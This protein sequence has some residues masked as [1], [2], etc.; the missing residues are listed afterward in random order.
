[1]MDGKISEGMGDGEICQLLAAPGSRWQP[2][3]VPL[4]GWDETQK[5]V[6]RLARQGWPCLCCD[7]SRAARAKRDGRSVTS[8][9]V[10]KT[11]RQI[12]PTT[13]PFLCSYTKSALR[14]RGALVVCLVSAGGKSRT[15]LLVRHVLAR[16]GG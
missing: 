11:S 16:H 7:G 10:L 5:G 4:A 6:A 15:V 12:P 1:L 8:G 3:A 13:T 9:R 14:P 2:K